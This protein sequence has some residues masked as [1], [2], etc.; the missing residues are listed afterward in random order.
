MDKC[1][2]VDWHWPGEHTWSNG[3]EQS[4]SKPVG[5]NIT[6]VTKWPHTAPPSHHLH[7]HIVDSQKRLA[8]WSAEQRKVPGLFFVSCGLLLSQPSK[9]GWGGE[10]SVLWSGSRA[11]CVSG[12]FRQMPGCSQISTPPPPLSHT[13]VSGECGRRTEL[14]PPPP[15]LY[16]AHRSPGEVVH[17]QMPTRHSWGGAQDSAFPPSFQVM[18]GLLVLRPYS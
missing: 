2:C 15:T 5:S 4:R 10:I 9:M 12:P 6:S 18:Q 17:T 3:R 7:V 1:Q 16:R 8:L 11:N 14:T 13:M